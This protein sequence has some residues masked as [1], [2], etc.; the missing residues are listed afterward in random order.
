VVNGKDAVN[1]HSKLLTTIL[2]VAVLAACSGGG[3]GSSNP[4]SQQSS[5][6][7]TTSDVSQPSGF[8]ITGSIGDG[9]IVDAE[10]VV[11]DR[12]GEVVATGQSDQEANYTIELP[13]DAALPLTIHVTGG[14]DLVTGRSADFELVAMI[15]ETGLQTANV[16]PLTTVAV[17]AAQCRGTESITGMNKSWDDLAS[18]FTVGFDRTELGDP[19]TQLINENN[20]ETAVLANEALGE[21]VRRT[22][23]AFGGLIPLDQIVDVLACDL[24][25]GVLDGQAIGDFE[26]DEKRI[27][28]VARASELVIRLEVV[29]GALRVDGMDATSAM[30]G[31]IRTI[32]PHVYDADVNNVPVTQDSLEDTIVVID[33]LMSVLPDPELPGLRAVLANANPVTA[34]DVL[35]V[36]MDSATLMTLDGMADRIALMDGWTIGEFGAISNGDV[37]NEEVIEETPVEAQTPVQETPVEEIPVGELPP[38]EEFIGVQPIEVVAPPVEEVPVTVVEPT[39]ELFVDDT[40]PPVGGSVR[41]NWTSQHAQSCFASDGWSGGLTDN[42]EETVSQIGVATTFTVTC[43]NDTGSDSASV[44]VTPTGELNITWQAPTE[45]VDG[46]EVSA[47][48]GYRI[49]YGVNTG[50]YTGVVEVAGEMTTHSMRLPL[51]EYYLAMTALDVVGQES[52]LSNE[53][54]LS[55]Q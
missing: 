54:L 5:S 55:V 30:N 4:P 43:T 14:T 38:A 44:N 24:A 35:G 45:N 11:R 36:E 51:G 31:A 26:Q 18:F 1:V 48:S 15:N 20:V 17:K 8:A 28:A 40:L 12:N 21:L 42:G 29:T 19:M 3:G 10:I 9:P 46:T 13:A 53:V 49:Q 23:S 50:Q 33:E 16:S 22:G 32:M 41:L 39:V 6:Q 27:F 7:I 52:D 34:T 47:L 2:I 25:D 37:L